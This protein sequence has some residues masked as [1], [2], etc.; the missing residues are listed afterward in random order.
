MAKRKTIKQRAEAIIADAKRYA[1]DTREAIANALKSKAADLPECV[2]RAEAGEEIWDLV[3]EQAKCEIAA[4]FIIDLFVVERMPTFIL[5]AVE[6]AL[7]KAAGLERVQIWDAEKG[8][9]LSA[10][11]SL[12]ATTQQLNL[13]MPRRSA[14]TP[15]SGYEKMARH[16][17]GLLAGPDTPEDLR[18]AIEDYIVELEN[19]TQVN[20]QTPE[21]VRVA[22]PL[23]L[24]VRDA[25]EL[26]DA[27][28]SDNTRA[29][30]RQRRE[31]QQSDAKTNR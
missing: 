3:G 17:A 9:S 26:N 11:A 19:T 29:Y 6:G 2:R 15:A 4:Q 25:L 20:V 27:G 12:F 18:D 21:V 14:E 31:K 23:M 5:A 8:L 1:P 22:L 10:V 13:D 30:L 7:N 24:E 28:M 16:V